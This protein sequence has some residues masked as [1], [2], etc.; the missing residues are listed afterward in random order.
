MSKNKKLLIIGLDGVSW[1]VLN[2]MIENGHM[3]F[4]NDFIRNGKSGILKSTEPPITPTAWTSFM[5]GLQPE[6]HGVWGFRNLRFVNGR[7][8][9]EFNDS[10]SIRY[11][12][13]WQVLSKHNKKVCVINLPL[14]YPPFEINGIMISGFPTPAG[15]ECKYTYPENFQGELLKAIPDYQTINFR[16]WADI[17]NNHIETFIKAMINISSQRAYL[18]SYL[19][20]REFWDIFMVHFQE[21][22]FIQHRYWHYIDR[23]HRNYSEAGFNECAKYYYYLDR[24]LRDIVAIAGGKGYSIVLMS[25]HGFQRCEYQFRINNWLFLENYLHMKKSIRNPLVNP[26]KKMIRMLPLNLKLKFSNEET[27]FRFSNHFLE[28]IIDYDKSVLFVEA[29]ATNVARA[30]FIKTDHKIRKHVIN[31]ILRLKTP[32]GKKAVAE[33]LPMPDNDNIYNILF[34]NAIVPTGMIITREPLFSMPIAGK[35]AQIG[36]HHKSGIIVIDNSLKEQELPEEIHQVFHFILKLQEIDHSFGKI[37]SN[38][39][40]KLLT[41]GEQ[42]QIQERLR[43]L[44]YL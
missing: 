31:D 21:T 27:K 30:Y 12:N 6:I 43:N 16:N 4:L 32:E 14:T 20:N 19:L 24:L 8:K 1:N 26:L 42:E 33:I 44:G 38:N 9:Y 23:T 36:V 5:T 15:A 37:F 29:N 22:D 11:K 25:D 40:V 3:P 28:K 18:S 10:S 41:N 17:N 39:P 35:S 7:L 13:I 2:P 34:N